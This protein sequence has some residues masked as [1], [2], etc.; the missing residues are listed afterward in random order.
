MC[1][2]HFSGLFMAVGLSL[3]VVIITHLATK[4]ILIHVSVPIEITRRL[5]LGTD[6]HG[7]EY[8]YALAFLSTENVLYR[9]H[10]HSNSPWS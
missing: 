6:R 4:T 7:V 5:A 3:V 10:H 9:C 1:Y 2:M 8:L